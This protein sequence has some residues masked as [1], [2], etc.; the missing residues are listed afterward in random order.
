MS[1]LTIAVMSDLH[2]Y[3]EIVDGES[4]SWLST[5]TPRGR[6]D[7]HPISALRVLIKRELP[8]ADLLLCPGDLGDKARPSAIQYAWECVHEIARV[9]NPALVAATTGNHDCDSRYEHTD[10]DAK[11]L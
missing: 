4:P 8:K 3:D 6:D 11:G 9:L 2:V 10:F 7:H 5:S 1:E